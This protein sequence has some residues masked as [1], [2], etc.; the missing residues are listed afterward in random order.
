[1]Q[2]TGLYCPCLVLGHDTTDCIVTLQGW[3][4]MGAQGIGHNMARAR[5][6]HGRAWATIRCTVRAIR[7]AAH[8]R[9]AWLG[10]SVV[11]QSFVS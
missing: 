9:A 11:I 7:P 8:V 10:V 3:A 1:M 4:G 6:R 2:E 5:P